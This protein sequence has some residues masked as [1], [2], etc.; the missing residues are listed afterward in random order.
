MVPFRHIV[1]GRVCLT[2]AA[3]AVLG[4]PLASA[5]SHEP[6]SLSVQVIQC[7]E[8][9]SEVPRL[10]VADASAYPKLEYV[11]TDAFVQKAD[12]GY[13]ILATKIAQ[14]N[15]FYRVESEHCSNY[16]Q[17]AVLGGHSRTLSMV[18]YPRPGVH[19]RAHTK[20]FG[21][22]NAVAGTLPLRPDVGWIVAADGS[23]RVLDLQDGAFYIPRVYPGRYRLRLELHGGWQTEIGI[24]LSSVP[25]K[26][27]VEHDL[28]LATIR[29]N[30]GNILAN[31]N[32]L[33]ECDYCY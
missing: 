10:L 33:K 1:V 3:L 11:G 5:T 14:G 27:L 15:Y 16:A 22:E 32:T 2:V 21:I 28:N 13:F 18:L 4:T 12:D 29:Q 30:I 31:G 19:N 25:S 8:G 24:D 20:L 6:A 7:R 9:R 26:Q 17:D 23:K